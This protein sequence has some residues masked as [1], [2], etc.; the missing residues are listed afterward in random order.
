MTLISC[1]ALPDIDD[2]STTRKV[3]TTVSTC[4]ACTIRA[5]RE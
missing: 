5:R 3:W 4:V 2:E 1:S